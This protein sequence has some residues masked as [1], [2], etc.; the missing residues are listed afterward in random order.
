MPCSNRAGT[1]GGET[2]D[3][4]S[5]ERSNK[6]PNGAAER[7][8]AAQSADWQMDSGR[9]RD[10]IRDQAAPAVTARQRRRSVRSRRIA[11]SLQRRPSSTMRADRASRIAEEAARAPARQIL[12]N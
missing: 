11:R 10:Q 12:D 8:T 6:Q 2:T 3:D 9:R 5:L 4:D 7:S 1:E